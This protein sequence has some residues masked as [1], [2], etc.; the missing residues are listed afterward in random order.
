MNA[1]RELIASKDNSARRQLRV[2]EDGTV[3]LSDVIGNH[4]L[5][6]VRFALA[7]WL[8]GNGY[9]GTEAA[10]DDDWVKS[11]YDTIEKHWKAGT[12]DVTEDY[13]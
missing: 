6:G 11:V 5:A 2:S 12:R 4:Q 1:L 7:T 10:K 9:V 3:Y 13:A 8:E